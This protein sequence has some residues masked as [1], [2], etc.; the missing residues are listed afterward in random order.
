[1][2]LLH[3][4]RFLPVY[5]PTR[6]NLPLGEKL[7]IFS[8]GNN[9]ESERAD[10]NWGTREKVV[11][12]MLASW[13][14]DCCSFSEPC[15]RWVGI[16][17][18]LKTCVVFL[19]QESHTFPFF[20]EPYKLCSQ[21]CIRNMETCLFAVWNLVICYLIMEIHIPSIVF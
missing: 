16:S 4:P 11:S 15:A 17:A 12:H 6:R 13:T 1:M 19:N 18:C 8:S 5:L 7:K 10:G 14:R 9:Q 20:T 21:L 2:E 3:L